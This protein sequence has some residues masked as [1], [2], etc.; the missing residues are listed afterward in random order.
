M[1]D[2]PIDKNE[3]IKDG[4]IKDVIK[5]FDNWLKKLN[6]VDTK[7]KN[8]AK[9]TTIKPAVNTETFAGLLKDTDKLEKAYKKQADNESKLTVIQRERLKLTKAT[10]V[11]EAKKII[12]VQKENAELNKLRAETNEANKAQRDALKTAKAQGNAYKKLELETRILKNESKRLGAELL[13]LGGRTKQNASQ[14]DKLSNS[15][16][17]A[18]SS[19]QAGDAKLKQLDKTVGDNYRNVGFYEKATRGLNKA[20]GA[21]GIA[22]GLSQLKTFAGDLIEL[23]NLSKGV[24]FAFQRLGQRGVDAFNRIKAS[25][26]GTLSDLEI[27]KSINEFENFNLSLEKSDVLFEFL[28]VAASQTGKSVDKLRDSLVEGLSKESKLRIDNLGISAAELNEELEKT[29]SFIDA[30]ANIAER[31]LSV[32]GDILDSAGNSQSKFNAQIENTKNLLANELQ[33]IFEKGFKA[34]ALTLEFLGN[35]LGVILKTIGLVIKSFI[36]YKAITLATAF[37]NKVLGLSFVR[38]ARSSG[39]LIG[40]LK[41]VGGAFKSLGK[42]LKA[43][44]FGIALFVIYEL[45]DALS[46]LQTQIN[47]TEEAQNRLNKANVN[48]ENS[49]ISRKNRLETLLVVA[50]DELRTKED[51]L[52]AIKAINDISPELLGNLTLE[53]VAKKEGIRITDLYIQ[54]ILKEAKVKAIQ[55]QIDKIGAEIVENDNKKLEDRTSVLDQN[56]ARAKLYLSQTLGIGDATSATLDLVDKGVEN[57]FKTRKGLE[58]QAVILQEQLNTLIDIDKITKEPIKPDSDGGNTKVKE[59]YKQAEQFVE[60]NKNAAEFLKTELEKYIQNQKDS[61]FDLSRQALADNENEPLIDETY[62]KR[63]KQE[64]ELKEQ[65][66]Q[67][68]QNFSST[69]TSVYQNINSLIT[70]SID[71]AIEGQNRL[72]SNSERTIDMIKQS[73]IAG[74]EQA[75][76]SILA[77]E[78]A[79]EES[80]RRIEKAQRRKQRMELISSGL[81]TYNSAV[82]GGAKPLEA[83][84]TTGVTMAGLFGLLS[85]LP[86]FDIGADRLDHKGRGVDGIG[87][88]PAIVHPNER[89]MT[90][91][92]NKA[93]GYNFTNPEIV[94]VMS[95][96]KKGLLSP[97][98]QIAIAQPIQDNSQILKSINEGFGK[99]NNYNM[100]FEELFSTFSMIVE[101]KKGGD[102]HVSKKN[103]KI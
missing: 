84:S 23:N 41:G 73:A 62:N 35:N 7:I 77:E 9:S 52:K 65:R 14:W 28:S 8:I 58:E 11:A 44:I 49:I 48:A 47:V 88:M 34:G 79:I 36:V 90:S 31:R 60:D 100:S 39:G 30:V 93:I 18:T 67:D 75:K 25:T 56:I 72:I 70:N 76:A 4:A 66:Q 63:I 103:F 20:L 78:K 24:E 40:V 46:T 71:T 55:A 45:Y 12:A 22:F 29:P 10:E 5:E 98:T 3:I 53:N 95:Y 83:L 64:N 99:I 42:V 26:R 33:P 89:I 97:S 2:Q 13:A 92:Q 15:Y 19:A 54:S 80:Q 21:L 57:Q 101:K 37:Q 96:Y 102:I 91:D 50:K 61:Q 69:I 43:N 32:A 87:G 6:Q 85:S 27:K 59:Q 94:D 1:A 81:N 86:S 74:N 38:I 51:R 82:A 17:V 16:K 68:L